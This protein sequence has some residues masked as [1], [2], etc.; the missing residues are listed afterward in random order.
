MYIPLTYFLIGF[1]YKLN[2]VSFRQFSAYF[3]TTR[4]IE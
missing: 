3:C 4:T 2:L 1:K